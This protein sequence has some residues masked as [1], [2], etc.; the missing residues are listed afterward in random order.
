MAITIS[1]GLQ[2]GGVGKT[3]S[4][5]ITSF[6]L[7]KDS[8]VLAIDLDGQGNLTE[9]LSSQHQIEIQNTVYNVIENE[10]V[11]ACIYQLTDKLDLIPANYDISKLSNLVTF[12]KSKQRLHRLKNALTEVQDQYDYILID[13]PPALGEQTLFGLIASDY[14][15]SLLQ[16]DPFALRALDDYLTLCKEVNEEHNSDLRLLGILAVLLNARAAMDQAIL[17][18]VK[19]DFGE[20]VFENVVKRRARIKEYAAAGVTDHTKAD[21]I[22]LEEYEGFVKELVERV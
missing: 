20:L 19:E 2:K 1:F 12:D 16:T 6:I 5:A 7:S 21:K 18:K 15:V 13:L 11:D 4:T 22:A 14:T 3:T 17:T 9:M 8:K 10:S